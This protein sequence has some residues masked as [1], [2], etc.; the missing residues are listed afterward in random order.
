MGG[1]A[2]GSGRVPQ[3]CLRG[4][5]QYE[6]RVQGWIAESKFARSRSRGSLTICSDAHQIWSEVAAHGHRRKVVPSH[7]IMSKEFSDPRRRPRPDRYVCQLRFLQGRGVASMG[8]RHGKQ[9]YLGTVELIRRLGLPSGTRS[10][11][12]FRR[13][14]R[15]PADGSRSGTSPG[16]GPAIVS[17]SGLS[18]RTPMIAMDLARL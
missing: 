9:R 5:G 12:G 10:A 8:D 17:R 14:S 4:R 1:V 13:L 15:L 16:E 6:E 11:R 7:R 18:S 3:G 2:A